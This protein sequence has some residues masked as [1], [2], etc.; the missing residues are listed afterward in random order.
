VV[1]T[2]DG[3]LQH[4]ISDPKMKLPKTY[5][6]QV[7][8]EPMKSRCGDCALASTSTTSSRD[9]Q[10]H[11]ASTSHPGYGEIPPIRVRKSIPTAGSNWN[12]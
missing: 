12:S 2:D 5:W 8:G 3:K 7:D 11:G 6:V 4:A 1:L 9:R 10:A